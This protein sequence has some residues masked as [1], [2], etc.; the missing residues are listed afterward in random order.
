MVQM[1]LKKDQRVELLRGVDLFSHCSKR[2]L[3]HL[4]SLTT[5]H[6]AKAG[7]ILAEQ[8]KPGLEFFVIV[9]GSATAF[10]NGVQ[11]TT[12]GPGS[13]FGELALLDGE[14]RT[15]TV[16]AESDIRLLVLTRQEFQSLQLLAPS[17]IYKM[18]VEI[19][20][21]LRKADVMLD[22]GYLVV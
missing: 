5:E 11:L 13:F 9:E 3:T 18:L 15:A 22:G 19:G 14:E 21:R 17:V 20:S 12:L 8:G 7:S 10:R 6:N 16:E 2:E 1:R 4:A